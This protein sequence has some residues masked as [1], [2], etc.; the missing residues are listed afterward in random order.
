MDGRHESEDVSPVR[1]R[2]DLTDGWTGVY[3]F[4]TRSGQEADSEPCHQW[5]DMGV[6]QPAVRDFEELDRLLDNRRSEGKGMRNEATA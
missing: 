3:P 2:A 5:T 4:Y 1:M 6:K